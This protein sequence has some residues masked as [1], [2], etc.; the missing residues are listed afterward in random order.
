[1]LDIG[2]VFSNTFSMMKERWL[3]LLGLWAVFLGILIVYGIIAAGV[4][5]GSIMAMAGGLS[6]PSAAALGGAGIGFILIAIIFYIGYF[7]IIFGQQGSMIALASP[8]RR[9]SFGDALGAGLKGGLTFLGVLVLFIIAYIAFAIVAAIF[10]FILS[11]LGEAAAV[12]VAILILP[13]IIYLACRFAVLV[14]VIVV[15]RVFNPI[16]AITRCWEVT[17]G[18][19]LGIFVVLIITV[20]IAAIMLGV[21]FMLFFGAMFATTDPSSISAG[22]AVG[23][24]I[25]GVLVFFLIYL[26]YMIFSTCLSASLHAEISDAEAEDL[27]KTF[28]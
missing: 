11:F 15:E 21:P 20:V 6:D 17:R 1:M 23:G 22:S 8:L 9:I 25:L 10:G 28:E 24:A 26:V 5:G 19:V 13:A 16:R 2:N 3:P 12:I 14:P 27:G 7:A 4:L 18:N